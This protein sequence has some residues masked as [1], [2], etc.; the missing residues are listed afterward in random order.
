MWGLRWGRHSSVHP[1]ALILSLVCWQI[2]DDVA[3]IVDQ[4]QKKQKVGPN[5]GVV[6]SGP[7]GIR[8]D[9]ASDPLGSNPVEAIAGGGCVA[10]AL[11]KLG[12]FSSKEEAVAARD[13]TRS[14][15]PLH[16]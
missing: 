1:L 5:A 12:I 4:P 9:D 8:K 10:V 6:S 11:W 3:P 7:D 14:M 13:R 15:R 16:F 2:I